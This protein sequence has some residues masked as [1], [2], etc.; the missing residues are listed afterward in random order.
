MIDH[1]KKPNFLKK[2]Y[3]CRNKH[4]C[5]WYIIITLNQGVNAFCQEVAA[6]ESNT[7]NIINENF[8]DFKYIDSKYGWANMDISNESNLENYHYME[9]SLRLKM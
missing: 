2:C 7:S 9:G 8:Y 5:T 3:G 6:G 4:F 1:E